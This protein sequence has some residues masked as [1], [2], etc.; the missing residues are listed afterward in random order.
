MNLDGVANPDVR[1]HPRNGMRCDQWMVNGMEY[2][3][4]IPD[5]LERARVVAPHSVGAGRS[6]G[7]GKQRL[8]SPS[9]N[10][11]STLIRRDA[12]VGGCP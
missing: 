10:C 7:D 11:W 6:D 4:D 12:R 8:P 1:R 3:S 9:T 5:D 2:L